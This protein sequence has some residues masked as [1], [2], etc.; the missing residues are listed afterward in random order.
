MDGAVFAVWVTKMLIEGDGVVQ[1]F[2]ISTGPLTLKHRRLVVEI[3]T[4][5]LIRH[6]LLI[7]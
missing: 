7:Y 2:F 1:S 3:I 4:R 6:T 5:F